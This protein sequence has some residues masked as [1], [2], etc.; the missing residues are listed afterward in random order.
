MSA[1]SRRRA[2]RGLTL[3]ELLVATT[4]SALTVAAATTL[5]VQ[6]QRSYVAGAGDRAQQEAGRMALRELTRRLRVAG[7][8]V[9]S[10]I[11]LDFGATPVVPRSNLIEPATNVAFPGHQCA[12]DVRCRDS[13][14]EDA[15][16]ELV[17]LTRDPLFSRVASA[18]ADTSLTL[19]G[20]LKQPM[21]AGQLLQVSCLGGTRARA[22]VTVER[23]VA[24]ASPADPT[25]PLAVQLLPGT[26]TGG[27]LTF[28]REN[29][30][31]ADAC[32]S[33]ATAG[34]QPIVTS[35]DRSRFYV[36]WYSEAGAV[37]AAQ[38]AGAR[39]YLMLD[40][41]LGGGGATP[42]PIAADVEDLQ[43]S[44]LYGPAVAGGPQRVVGA[45]LGT[46][47]ADEAFPVTTAVVPPSYDDV[48]DAASR[49]TGHA[50]NING[51][52]VAVVVRSAEP[53]I[54]L[55]TDLDRTLPAAGNRAAFLGQPNYR[56]S[57]FE[58]T[59][60]L[61]NLQT[62]SFTFPTVNAAGGTGFNLG[63]G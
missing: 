61:R 18:V 16:D 26:T 59:V 44:Y 23:D 60:L 32:F 10:N 62:A 14:D 51:I 5:L 41:G 63:G 38:T 37:V 25:A 58:T 19:V 46:N 2:P 39:P 21:Y 12:S 53:D 6:Q 48:P 13:A 34:L 20:Q 29:T 45:A 7:Y 1:A 57:L 27:L 17:F 54:S 30:T 31:L 33:I 8:G 42:L 36:A 11:V 43:L 40:R 47:I 56:R 9:D 22:Y 35:V 3:I 49:T 52:R 4:V 55:V 28:G 24:A 50:S 15:S